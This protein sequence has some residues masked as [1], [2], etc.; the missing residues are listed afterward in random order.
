MV[1]SIVFRPYLHAL[2]LRCLD[3]ISFNQKMRQLSFSFSFSLFI[4]QK[5]I[6]V[7]I[8]T[9]RNHTCSF[10]NEGYKN[11]T[12][13]SK[14]IRSLKD[15]EISYE[16]NWCKIRQAGSYSNIIKKGNLCL[17]KKYFIICNPEMSSLN[18]RKELT[19]AC[20]HSKKFLSNTVFT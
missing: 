6:Y 19:S 7:Y 9:Q 4:C 1:E 2:F 12:E 3:K 14:L 15:M 11:T 20:R 16:I 8:Q 13:L 10:R 5:K 18:H 17:W